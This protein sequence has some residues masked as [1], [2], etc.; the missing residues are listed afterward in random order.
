[1]PQLAH[2]VRVTLI[3]FP[4]LP[5]LLLVGLSL[6]LL[7]RAYGLLEMAK[8]GAECRRRVEHSHI[9][10]LESELINTDYDA[11]E[12]IIETLRE[13]QRIET[14]RR[15]AYNSLPNFAGKIVDK[16]ATIDSRQSWA[17]RGWRGWE[18]DEPGEEW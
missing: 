12:R 8:W 2:M 7:Y 14:A 5:F 15:A 3:Y 11:F 17:G 6:P 1:M 13:D 16:V 10:K 4:F 9:S 18:D